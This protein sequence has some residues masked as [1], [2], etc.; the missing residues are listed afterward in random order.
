MPPVNPPNPTSSNNISWVS[1][2]SSNPEDQDI[3]FDAIDHIEMEEAWFEGAEAFGIH[4]EH[5]TAPSSSAGEAAD[6]RVPFTED[7]RRGVQQLVR[8]LGEYGESRMLSVCLSK[9]LP[10]TPTSLVIAANSLYTAVTERRNI[11]TAV[12]HTLGLASCYLPENINIVSRLASFL[13]DTVTGW[14]DETFLQ[15]FL[16]NEENHTSTHLFTALAIT[17][18]VAG[19]WMKD[20]GPPQ[21]GVLKV[22]AFMANIFIRASHYWTALG[23]MAGSL[24]SGTAIPE[25][26]GTSQP[27][28]AFEVDT[29]MEMTEDV[30]DAT[31]SG[32]SAPRLT[33]FSSNSTARPEAYTHAT[34][35]N[36]PAPASGK[37]T[38][39]S[40]PEQTHYLAVEKLR[41]ESGLS[42]LLYC[43]TSKTE[44]RQQTNE[45][46]ITSTYFN[47]KCDATDYPEPLTKGADSIP[48][49]TDI[50]ETQV[51]S[52]ATS[53]SGGD[54]LLPLVMTGAVAVPV[55]TSYMQALKNKKMIGAVS[56][57]GLVGAIVG[58]KQLWDQFASGSTGKGSGGNIKKGKR[59]IQEGL[60]QPDG[61]NTEVEIRKEQ[62]KCLSVLF[63]NNKMDIGNPH[64]VINNLVTYLSKGKKKSRMN[65]VINCLLEPINIYI[66]RDKNITTDTLK[67]LVLLDYL[68]VYILG[69]DLGEWFSNQIADIKS[70]KTVSPSSK[71][72]SDK[73]DSVIKKHLS[74]GLLAKKTIAFYKKIV[75]YEI[76]ALLP[77]YMG[78]AGKDITHIDIT[79]AQW[80]LVHAGALLLRDNNINIS[81]LSMKEIEEVG[82]TLSVIL[83]E[84]A[85]PKEYNRYFNTPAA[86]YSSWNKDGASV[87]SN[88]TEEDISKAHKNYFSYINSWVVEN[89]P[90]LKLNDLI[91]KWKKRTDI[92]TNILR[93]N[94]INV[95]EYLTYYLNAHDKWVFNKDQILYGMKVSEQLVAPNVITLP[96]IDEIFQ[97]QNQAIA[98]VIYDLDKLLL[99]LLFDSSLNDDDKNF[100]QNSRV[101]LIKANLVDL[102]PEQKSSTLKGAKY[103][104]P[105]EVDFI[106]CTSGEN[107]RFYSIFMDENSKNYTMNRVDPDR[108]AEDDEKMRNLGKNLIEAHKDGKRY[109]IE[110]CKMIKKEGESVHLLIENLSQEHRARMK[111][112]LHA[113][114]YDETTA[115]KIKETLLSFIPFYTCITESIKGNTGH[116]L[117]SC[118]VDILTMLPAAADAAKVA[119]RF[120][121]ALTST[122]V[123]AIKY[124]A[125]QVTVSQMIKQARI[126]FIELSPN[127]AREISPTTLK[128]LGVS[129]LRALD[130]G[131]EIIVLG[132]YKGGCALSRL[133]QKI[134]DA[135]AGIKKLSA[136]MR[137]RAYMHTDALKIKTKYYPGDG[138]GLGREINVVRVG[139][140]QDR[141]IWA[142]FNSELGAPFGKKYIIDSNDIIRIAPKAHRSK[143]PKNQGSGTVVKG[144]ERFTLLA[145]LPR[146]S[147]V[148]LY[149]RAIQRT[150]KKYGVIIGVRF[151]NP[152]G[153]T[154]LKEGYP[155]KNFHLKAK[156][157]GTGPTSGFIA[158]KP[159]YS[160]VSPDNYEKQSKAIEDAIKKGAESVQLIL[161]KARIKE[162]T[163]A[164]EMSHLQSDI[165]SAT[166]PG[167]K[168]T[169]HIGDDGAVFD[170]NHLPVKVL[171]NPPEAGTSSGTSN[172]KSR[173]VTVDY[174]LFCIIPRKQQDYN[175]NPIELRPVLINGRFELVSLKNKK[176][177][178][179]GEH[180][181]KGN[182][183]Y[184][185]E[186]IINNLNK[187]VNS[188]GYQ[189][190]KLF[191]HGDESMN[192][193]SPGL[194][195]SDKP[196]FF[197][198]SGQMTQAHTVEQLRDLYSIFKANGFPA[199]FSPRFNVYSPA[200]SKVSMEEKIINKLSVPTKSYT[201]DSLE[202][203]MVI[204]NGKNNEQIECIEMKGQYLPYK[205]NYN[206]KGG[207][208]EVYDFNDKDKWGY[209]VHMNANNEWTF[210]VFRSGLNFDTP[211]VFSDVNII[212][213]TLCNK[214]M[215]ELPGIP[216][217]QKDFSPVN[218]RNIV[219]NAKGERFIK[220]DN[221]LFRMVPNPYYKGHYILGEPGGN[222]L[223]CKYDSVTDRYVNV[224]NY[225]TKSG[226]VERKYQNPDSP[227]SDEFDSELSINSDI[228]EESYSNILEPEQQLPVQ[229]SPYPDFSLAWRSSL[230][231][232][233]PEIPNG[234]YA[235]LIGR[236]GAIYHF[237]NGPLKAFDATFPPKLMTEQ[238]Y[239]FNLQQYLSQTF[240]DD[241]VVISTCQNIINS[242]S[243]NMRVLGGKIINSA[244][245]ALEQSERLVTLFGESSTRHRVAD[246]LKNLLGTDDDAVI[247]EAVN[248]I[249]V[250]VN[251]NLEMLQK[252]S[253]NNFKN[254][255]IYKFKQYEKILEK[256]EAATT[257]A[258]TYSEDP[259]S[260]IHFNA[261]AMIDNTAKVNGRKVYLTKKDIASISQEYQNMIFLHETTHSSSNTVD[262]LYTYS[263]GGTWDYAS[264]QESINQFREHSFGGR[265]NDNFYYEVIGKKTMRETPITDLEKKM[266]IDILNIDHVLEAK[267]ILNNA[268]N[269]A[270]IINDI[271]KEFLP[272]LRRK[273]C[274]GYI[275]SSEYLNFMRVLYAMA[276][277]PV[278]RGN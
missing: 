186:T 183:N 236:D 207:A 163:A 268:D 38:R 158:E 259:E 18:I 92:A 50:T 187:E 234:A 228:E 52:A 255:Y 123:T 254:I 209:P 32:T 1:R 159:H 26:T 112:R 179:K 36:R 162:L 155:S 103:S 213:S 210:G 20:E 145:G 97:K 106:L 197:L 44:S 154:L 87:S 260:R 114:G 272:A 40:V 160:K 89:N 190:G 136:A 96:N 46:I 215:N 172:I 218:S 24:P 233:F 224:E 181:N 142:E 261:G 94:N 7:C 63:K 150:A 219:E 153:A 33:A 90:Y 47:T 111:D 133:I 274:A 73:F 117:A 76:P 203:K 221:K 194:D 257:N 229:Q 45:N 275:T 217:V 30:C 242:E 195:M 251:K 28:P 180:K 211:K 22:P 3:W 149:S 198:P 264:A 225:G 231:N 6:S 27:A 125:R 17:A 148:I 235:E 182:V 132:S 192:P 93:E 137:N 54:A 4:E 34:V 175:I 239:Q 100:I 120:G 42:D 263:E 232:V 65:K 273:R 216:F 258:F 223:Y 214:I 108:T 64:D 77:E 109:Y 267:L 101:E 151:P 170:D 185:T 75:S 124:G 204:V 107:V 25:N 161:S 119:G 66:P 19:R 246:H 277:Y 99:P 202:N 126:K 56:A 256:G 238:V 35:Q 62:T 9:I 135:G 208:I 60:I 188:E 262:Y 68:S 130:P 176:I 8:T 168:K 270:T 249:E 85:I 41:Q 95:E 247:N 86:A 110:Y 53:R 134:P 240:G 84:D 80:G 253:S 82:N 61:L 164:G 227:G 98:D 178:S 206:V 88:A 157:S 144:G 193:F 173:P 147:D 74:E 113:K 15:Q 220:I 13:R 122:G 276:G 230:R 55:A 31:A 116:A 146:A 23:N 43:A 78:P 143:M 237:P 252:T 39:I 199:E 128:G 169:F 21:R 83:K 245:T 118:S 278:L 102:F 269:L 81:D 127:I 59:E 174:D 29:Q 140:H 48:V 165:Y 115:E 189:G 200:I 156:S 141:G 79:E 243:D 248:F 10:G 152:R 138:P 58:G 14:T 222:H 121:Q 16:G 166:Y 265:M 91:E 12:L 266:A 191:W 184:F 201:V 241:N 129:L 49:H 167:G 70:S 11:D 271:D 226:I 177:G 72:L 205:I 69:S 139:S 37:N 57:F 71:I 131:G 105:E 244:R 171:T 212:G 67:R 2:D 51:S 104:I 250:A 196:I 5:Q